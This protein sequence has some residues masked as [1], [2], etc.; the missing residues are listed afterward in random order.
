MTAN[1]T[2]F[3]RA[4]A[5][6]ESGFTALPVGYSIPMVHLATLDTVAYGGH[7]MRAQFNTLGAGF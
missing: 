3:L 1:I 5:K 7:L 6:N 2:Y 4:Y